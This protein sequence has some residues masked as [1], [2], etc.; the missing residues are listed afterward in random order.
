MI[1]TVPRLARRAPPIPAVVGI[2]AFACYAVWS[3]ALHHI[4]LATGYDLGI[5]EQA[6]RSY[7]H[8]HWPVADLKAPGFPLLGDHFHPILA[9]LA[10]FYRLWPAPD[11]LLLAQAALLAVS[12]VPVTRCALTVLGAVRGAVFGAGYALSSGLLNAI[13]FDFHEICFAVPLLA[14]SAERLLR[15]QWAAAVAVAAPLV[16]V[17]EDLPLTFAAIGAYLV[18]HGQKRLG[19]ATIAAGF[20]I[21]A[22]LVGVVIPAINPTGHYGFAGR[23]APGLTDGLGLKLATLLLTF[24]P[25][26]FAG[27]R[28]RLSILLIP[29][30]AWRLLSAYPKYWGPGYHYNAVLMP[31]AF[32]AALD[33]LGTM[34]A[35]MRTLAPACAALTSTAVIAI[36]LPGPRPDR[37]AVNAALARIPNG[38]TV[39]AGSVFA[40][41]LTSRCRVLFFPEQPSP[42]TDPAWIVTSKPLIAWPIPVPEQERMLTNLRRTRYRTVLDTRDVLLLQ[43]A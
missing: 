13:T 35:R 17:K 22:V 40:P 30:L 16:L 18:W 43:R 39:A 19:W 23:M 12:A 38:A 3:L 14:F 25:T 33:A 7:A 24:G 34:G 32:L 2:V 4:W 41:H 21:T 15:R 10:P 5:F 6:V 20:T 27:L 28:S 8:G 42:S 31:V 26:A 29:T 9:L 36:L 11:T 37:T 1:R